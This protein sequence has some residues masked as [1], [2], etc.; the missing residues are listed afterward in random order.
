MPKVLIVDDEK[1]LAADVADYLA[2]YGWAA[3]SI[4]NG[5]E[6]LGVLDNS[7]DAVVLD[8]RMPV[9]S[10]QATFDAIKR[11]PDLDHLC[12][13]VLT[14]YGDV[15]NAVQMIRQGA[16]QY[17]QK[18]FGLENL[19]GILSSGTAWQRAHALRR[20]ILGSFDQDVLIRRIRSIIAEAI[21]PE[22]LYIILLDSEG[23]VI[24]GDPPD[25]VRA[26]DAKKRFVRHVMESK[27]P[28]FESAGAAEWD[29]VI[30]SA[31]SLLAAPVPGAQGRTAGVIDIESSLDNA[32][33]RN[34]IAVLE[35]LADLTGIS[36]E[37]T[38]QAEQN[39]SLK[40]L[41][42]FV[43]ELSH[44][45]STPLQVMKLQ[46]ETLISKELKAE[47]PEAIAGRIRE[48]LKAVGRNVDA[49]AQVRDYLRDITREMQVRRAPF[50]LLEALDSCCREFE[51]ELKGK[52][53]DL[54]LPEGQP[55][56]LVIEADV[57][58]LTYCFQCLLQNAIE[59]IEK[60]RT[61]GGTAA[62]TAGDRIIITVCCPDP[63]RVSVEV[64]DTGVGIAPEIRDRLFE[65]LFS[66]KRLEEP[67]GMGL[68]S[69]R[70]VL[71]M[72]GGSITEDSRADEGARFILTL[73]RK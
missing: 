55:E 11:R 42:I 56:G 54:S 14:A 52:R 66:T 27:E 35:Y 10:G 72:H 46:V 2:R 53:I 62:T 17:L 49:I 31:R 43:N 13:V 44:H 21:R 12:V 64:Q 71:N 70:R 34:W 30:P 19:M 26:S 29:P 47:V 8:L 9:M 59:S 18:P 15:D 57:H 65:P 48:R 22:G 5:Q 33:D 20:S 1:D 51:S 28:L 32:F 23:R 3:F 7:F 39:A 45:I 69:V 41:P 16:Y 40:A 36:L 67:S 38:R 37:L 68:F 24:G 25:A 4:N 60:R 6:A 61:G 58:L 63:E 50:D 73:P